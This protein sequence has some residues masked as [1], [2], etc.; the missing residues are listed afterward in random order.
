MARPLK[1]IYFR[2]EFYSGTKDAP[3]E[4]GDGQ[5]AKPGDASR[6]ESRSRR[7]RRFARLAGLAVLIVLCF[8]SR[9]DISGAQDYAFSGH[10]FLQAQKIVG[11]GLTVSLARPQAGQPP[12]LQFGFQSAKVYGLKL[13]GKS[14]SAE[15]QRLQSAVA[16]ERSGSV[17]LQNMKVD[18]SAFR[19][20]V[21]GGCLQAGAHPVDATLSNVGLKA[22]RLTAGGVS[23]PGST[24]G[25]PALM[26]SADSEPIAGGAP[27]I[28]VGSSLKDVNA[29]LKEL[30]GG[31]VCGAKTGGK[32]QRSSPLSPI[33]RATRASIPAD[34]LAAYRDAD[35]KYGVDWAILAAIGDIESGHG[36]GGHKHLCI[37]GP[38][39]PYGNAIGPMQFLPQTWQIAETDGDGNGSADAC[40]YKD[41]IFGAAK[42]LR[43]NGAPGDYF[44]AI[45]AYNHAGWYVKEVLALASAYR[46]GQPVQPPPLGGFSFCD[47]PRILRV[48]EDKPQRARI[49]GNGRAVFPLPRQYFG[50]Y[51]DSWGASRPQNVSTGASDIHEGVDLMA[52]EGT[53]IYSITGGT[54]EPVAGSDGAGWN[55]LGGWALM[56]RANHPIGPIHKGD[57]I[58]YAHMQRPSALKPGDH[59]KPGEVIGHVGN[60]GQG[61]D[62]TSGEFPSHLHL[63]WYDPTGQRAQVPSGAMNPYPLLNWLKENG[64]VARGGE[65]GATF[66]GPTVQSGTCPG[67]YPAGGYPATTAFGEGGVPASLSGGQANFFNPGGQ[68]EQVSRPAPGFSSSVKRS[69]VAYHHARNVNIE[70]VKMHHEQH[71][72]NNK[73]HEQRANKHTGHKAHGKHPRKHS[74][75]GRDHKKAPPHHRRR[76][77]G[78][79]HSPPPERASVGAGQSA[80]AG[81]SHPASEQGSASASAGSSGGSISE[82][83]SASAP[84][85]TG[86]S[87]SARQSASTPAG[88]QGPASARVSASAPAGGGSVGARAS[89][90]VSPESGSV[91]ASVDT[92][93]GSAGVSAGTSSSSSRSG[94]PPSS[95]SS[96]SSS[97]SSSPASSAPPCSSPASSPSDKSTSCSDSASG[98][99]GGAVKKVGKDAGL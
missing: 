20:A 7:W 31:G 97:P 39:T 76:A 63:G 1:W 25:Q 65:V 14:R 48:N 3:P 35:R 40:N 6:K 55:Y 74:R 62:G 53:P 2:R 22:S 61:P 38:P 67:A 93:V 83:Q 27:L 90:S 79:K 45:F 28:G 29:T 75:H 78:R 91:G 88:T 8:L 81:S 86:G 68:M 66:E 24:G 84:V 94:P 57:E 69:G 56:V 21:S 17:E 42:Y 46:N 96:S 19:F 10:F 34:Y 30:S 98:A 44:R 59:V 51:T 60:T 80:S 52:P 54:V 41:A 26:V 5:E 18:A 43:Q 77:P 58:Y 95:S 16:N 87:A 4:I 11:R 82:G 37:A 71:A 49:S 47:T 64:G 92:P 33:P 72:N 89:A 99:L 32:P 73:H 13:S 70:T 9:S 50:S 85:P 12:Q 36:E 15:F 23:F